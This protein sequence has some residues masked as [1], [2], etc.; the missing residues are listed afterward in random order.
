MKI[1][2]VAILK[3]GLIVV[4]AIALFYATSIAD[5]VATGKVSSHNTQDEAHYK[6]QHEHDNDPLAHEKMRAEQKKFFKDQTTLILEAI[7][8]IDR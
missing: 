2:L 6:A 5:T 1:D 3:G 4:I 7:S 8:E